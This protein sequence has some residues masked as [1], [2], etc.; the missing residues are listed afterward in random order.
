MTINSWS[1]LQNVWQLLL[2]L[3]WKRPQC[4]KFNYPDTTPLGEAPVGH[5]ERDR[6]MPGQLSEVPV[7]PADILAISE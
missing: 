6:D 7:I 4:K 1:S 3:S 2:T 5:V